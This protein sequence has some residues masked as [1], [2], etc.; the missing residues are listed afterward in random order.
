SVIVVEHDEETIRAADHVVELGPG[1]GIHGGKIVSEGTL[2]KILKDDRSL[3]G[4]YL[5]G[6][7]RI[8]IPAHRRPGNGKSIDI[9]GAR[10]NNLRNI[11]VEIPL[12]QFVCVTGASG[13]GKSS[14][15][16]E[17]VYKRLYSLLH[18]SRVFAGEHDE[19]TG[20]EYITDVID[21][22]QSPIGRSS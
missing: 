18:D 1:P 2:A 10:Q 7:K 17:I 13:S 21:V 12:E 8:G 9:R 16:H 15:I 11:D 5:S 20:S 3:T 4:Q 22:D 14:L 6:K 19:L